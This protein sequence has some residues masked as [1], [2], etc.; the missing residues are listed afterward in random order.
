MLTGPRAFQ[1]DI[2]MPLFSAIIR[3][4]LDTGPVVDISVSSGDQARRPGCQRERS[5]AIQDVLPARARRFSSDS[6]GR[7]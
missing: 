2:M 7:A 4:E 6:S 3:K 5:G 1:A